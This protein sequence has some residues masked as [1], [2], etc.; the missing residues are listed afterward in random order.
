M[1]EHWAGK[2]ETH[3]GVTLGAGALYG[4]TLSEWVGILT[5]VLLVGQIVWLGAKY[6]ITIYK[7]MNK[8][9]T[10]K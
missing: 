2:I 6:I 4:Y 8:R 7:W 5:V 1:N 10:K 3:L 9:G